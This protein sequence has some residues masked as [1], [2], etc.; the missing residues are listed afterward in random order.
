[1]QKTII[2]TGATSGIGFEL[3]KT[4]ALAN[5]K[6]IGIARNETLIDQC[7]HNIRQINPNVDLTFVKADLSSLEEVRVASNAI[8]KLVSLSGID[9]LINNAATVPHKKIMTS[10]GFEMQ[11]QVNHLSG[12][13]LSYLLYNELNKKH[14]FVITTT[15]RMHILSKFKPN[16]IMATKHYHMLR[17]YCRTKL[18]NL[19]FTKAFR[20]VLASS[21]VK[22]FAVHPGLVKTGIGTKSTNSLFAN[23]WNLSARRGKE[24][25]EVVATYSYII[26]N[27]ETLDPNAFYYHEEKVAIPHKRLVTTGNALTLW[28]IT[29]KQLKLDWDVLLKESTA[30]LNS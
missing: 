9:V 11:Y 26:E 2:V 25:I 6:V 15:S 30:S 18:Y 4:Y 13:Y 22:T 14:G 3:V 12:V 21:N 24:P 16:D 29:N 19:L 5:Y 23:I 10:D 7:N 27:I 1:M 17:S 20:D 8:K 28:N